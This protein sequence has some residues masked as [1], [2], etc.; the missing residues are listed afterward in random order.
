MLAAPPGARATGGSNVPRAAAAGAAR[1]YGRPMT[2]RRHL[3][4]VLALGLTDA[5]LL[6]VLL[7][8]AFVDRSDAAVHVL[9][10][11]HG[12]GFVL[13]VALTANGAIRRLWGWW[14]P[15]IVLATG[16]P[17]GTVVGDLVLRRRLREAPATS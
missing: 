6:L 17:P 8:V 7:Y 9:G 13:L 5:L 4:A 10:P 1:G 14:F 11:V 16:G 12:I 3:N 15:L 2:V